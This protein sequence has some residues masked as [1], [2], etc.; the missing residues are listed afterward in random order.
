MSFIKKLIE[1]GVVCNVATC[2]IDQSEDEI[3]E[4]S[5]ILAKIGVSMQTIALVVSQGNAKKNNIG[6]TYTHTRVKRLIEKLNSKYKSEKFNIREYGDSNEKNCGAGYNLLRIKPS[7]DITPC[8]M[9]DIGIGNLGLSDITEISKTF[10]KLFY[11]LHSP[12]NELCGLC[13]KKD[14]CGRCTAN[15][16]NE[17]NHCCW[18]ENQKDILNSIIAGGKACY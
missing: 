17:R 11:N 13:N 3:E 6:Q 2:L 8:P 10:C 9:I 4:L 1:R 15:G 7:L 5:G 14:I 18:Y 12:N 16:L